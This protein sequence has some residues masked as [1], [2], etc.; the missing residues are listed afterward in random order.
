MPVKMVSPAVL[1]VTSCAPSKVLSKVMSPAVVLLNSAAVVP[2]TT[3]SL[4]LCAPTVLT[5]PPLTKDLPVPSKSVVKLASASVKP[6]LPVKMVS[7]AVLMAKV[8]APFRVLAK[9]ML[10]VPEL[11]NTVFTPKVTPPL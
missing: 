2:T 1:M 8:F 10:P 5:K 11:V 6:T 3:G 9:L 4:K 7:P